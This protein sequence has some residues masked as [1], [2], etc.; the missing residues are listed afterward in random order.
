VA[1]GINDYTTFIEKLLIELK[2]ERTKEEKQNINNFKFENEIN[3]KKNNICKILDN[4]FYRFIIEGLDESLN[5][6]IKTIIVNEIHQI[7]C[8]L[9][10]CKIIITTRTGTILD[11][12]NEGF[13]RYE[14]A[15]L[16]L[17]QKN[18]FVSKWLEDINRKEQFFIEMSKTPYADSIDKPINL[19]TLCAIYELD[20]ELQEL[21]CDVYGN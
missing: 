18:E 15:K 9:Q 11:N 5:E 12:L 20:D 17:K 10:K 2:K 16:S 4:T 13:I 6:N 19:A 21:P 8:N 14:I 3:I 1:L 7:S